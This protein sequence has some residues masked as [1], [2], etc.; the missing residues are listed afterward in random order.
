MLVRRVAAFRDHA[1][2]AELAGVLEHG[3]AVGLVQI[4]PDAKFA[5]V[6]RLTHCLDKFG[7]DAQP[8][9]VVRL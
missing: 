2:E 3:P 1:L 4:L 6:S 5:V 9:I 7:R 8:C